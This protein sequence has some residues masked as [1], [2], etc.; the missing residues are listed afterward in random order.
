MTSNKDEFV[1][2][3]LANFYRGHQPIRERFPNIAKACDDIGVDISSDPIPVVPAAHYFCCGV[4]SNT[5]GETTLA[6]LYTIGQ[7]SYTGLHGGDR[8][9]LTPLPEGLS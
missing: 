9:A 2:L 8:P 1:Y 3:D 7:T 4:L 5:N 6:R